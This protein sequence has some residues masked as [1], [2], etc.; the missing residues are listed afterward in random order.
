M[1][2]V[3][4]NKFIQ[5]FIEINKNSFSFLSVTLRTDEGGTKATSSSS[6]MPE[7]PTISSSLKILVQ[8]DPVVK[9][10][11]LWL[12]RYRAVIEESDDSHETAG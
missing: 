11:L 3:Y 12:S 9:T 8:F 5:I 4:I 1:G 6:L 7:Y 2:E 10:G